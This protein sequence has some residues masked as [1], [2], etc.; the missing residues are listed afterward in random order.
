MTLNWEL[1]QAGSVVVSAEFLV[2]GVVVLIA[3][4]LRGNSKLQSEEAT[5]GLHSS[6]IQTSST[7]PRPIPDA[8]PVQRFFAVGTEPHV[9]TVDHLFDSLDEESRNEPWA[10]QADWAELVARPM[11][12]KRRRGRHRYMPNKL[13][14]LAPSSLSA[15]I[16]MPGLPFERAS[17]LRAFAKGQQPDRSQ[18]TALYLRQPRSM[19]NRN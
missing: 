4:V 2:L 3:R 18:E 17:E 12:H 15:P 5:L 7:G 9:Q 16:K 13:I 1:I 11:P 8:A 6:R 19:S 10:T 14:P